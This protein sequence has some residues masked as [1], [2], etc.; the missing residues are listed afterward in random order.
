MPS[1]GLASARPFRASI[2]CLLKSWPRPIMG[3]W[4]AWIVRIGV[5]ASAS[6]VGRWRVP[7]WT[8]VDRERGPGE[9]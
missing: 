9:G 7:A 4:E 2:R 3:V 8:F 5:A 1:R 6:P